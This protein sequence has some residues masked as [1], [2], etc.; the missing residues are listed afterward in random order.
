MN[1]ILFGPPGAGKGTQATFLTKRFD[2]PQISTGDMLRAA[3]KAGTALGLQAKQIMDSGGL[4]SDEI[5]LGLVEER[6][7]QEDCNNGFILDGFPRTAIQAEMLSALLERIARKIDA[8][9]FL[10]VDKEEL[11]KRI[12]GRRSCPNCNKGYHVE[13]DPPQTT[14]VC[15]VCNTGLVQRDDDNEVTVLHRLGLYESQTY[16]LKDFFAKAGLVKEIDGIGD[17]GEIETRINRALD[18]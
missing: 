2:I 18:I 13:N 3:V 7:S 8:V 6:L 1:L 4:V 16:P 11:V 15:D 10:E 14:N 12:S 17:I 9:I 5:V